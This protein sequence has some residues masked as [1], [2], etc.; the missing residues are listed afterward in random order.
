MPNQ[1][2]QPNAIAAARRT[3][4][5]TAA[6]I[7]LGLIMLALDRCGQRT[8]FES[9]GPGNLH[10]F[11][12]DI[13]ASSLDPDLVRVTSRRTLFPPQGEGTSRKKAIQRLTAVCGSFEVKE[14]ATEKAG[15]PWKE[16]GEGVIIDYGSVPNRL[17]CLGG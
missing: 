14:N 4:K 11:G 6:A 2:R 16:T 3:L 1:E 15:V 13:D 7:G 10:G 9:A 12:Y 17:A 8:S 5:Y